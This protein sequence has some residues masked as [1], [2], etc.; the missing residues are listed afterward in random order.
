MKKII[1]IFDSSIQTKAQVGGAVSVDPLDL[2]FEYDI[3]YQDLNAKTNKE[4]KK[5]FSLLY[6]HGTQNTPLYL[7]LED[8]KIYNSHYVEHGPLKK[9][10]VIE[11]LR[12]ESTHSTGSGEV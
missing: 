7:F 5:A 12:N 4:R 3:E 8:D 1:V 2:S 9:S 10:M 6:N 11:K